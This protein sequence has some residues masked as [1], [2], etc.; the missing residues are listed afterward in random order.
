MKAS[1]VVALVSKRLAQQVA[2]SAARTVGRPSASPQKPSVIADDHRRTAKVA[3][4]PL[5]LWLW[6]LAGRR[7]LA[8]VVASTSAVVAV[9]VSV[10]V[11]VVVVVVA[12]AVVVVVAVAVAVVERPV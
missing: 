12:V 8:R 4:A 10:V 2:S 3:L 11:V 1:S 5:R 9:A 6:T 7:T